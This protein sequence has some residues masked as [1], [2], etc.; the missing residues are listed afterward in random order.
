MHSLCAHP[1]Q[2]PQY[3][4]IRADVARGIVIVVCP[5]SQDLESWRAPV[6]EGSEHR[7]VRVAENQAYSLTHC[8][9]FLS[10]WGTWITSFS[11]R[12]IVLPLFGQ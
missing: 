4:G 11:A 1:K 8:G 5:L 3:S 9:A 6:E 7:L 12:P 2:N 10:R